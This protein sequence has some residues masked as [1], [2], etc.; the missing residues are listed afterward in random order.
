M[1]QQ[2]NALYQE[3]SGVRKVVN[4]K[5]AEI[6]G[7]RKEM[8][9]MKEGQNDVKSQADKVTELIN[10]V[11]ADI[12]ASFALKDSTREEYYKA[13]Y[14]YEEQRDKIHHI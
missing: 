9:A 5:D 8:E 13:R 3:L 6:E 2:K 4:E 14:N 1:I 12:T 10:K 11:S 7:L